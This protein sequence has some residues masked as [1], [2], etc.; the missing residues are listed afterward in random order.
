M[1]ERMGYL[2]T[3][4]TA[5]YRWRGWRFVVRGACGLARRNTRCAG[6]EEHERGM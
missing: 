5:G 3:H 2:G 4:D 1:S 6:S